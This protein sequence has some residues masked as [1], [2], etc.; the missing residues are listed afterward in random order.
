VEPEWIKTSQIESYGVL[1]TSYDYVDFLD[2]GLTENLHR[3]AGH[4]GFDD[5]DTQ[6]EHEAPNGSTGMRSR[7]ARWW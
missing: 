1:V 5:H 6:R 4:P 3:C 2:V 7:T